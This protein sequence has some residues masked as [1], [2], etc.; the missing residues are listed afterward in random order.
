MPVA[1]FILFIAL[2]CGCKAAPR[3]AESEAPR[4]T[5]TATVITP[6]Q[7]NRGTPVRGP[8]V[9]PVEALS[10]RVIAVR[11]QLRF[12]IV[13][14]PNQKLPRLDQLLSVYRLDQKVAEI[15]VSGPY[16]GSTVAADITA[17]EVREGDLVRDL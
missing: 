2:L 10:G 15:K 12:V 9:R 1:A 3:K 11:E 16:L 5:V 4:K 7:A 17:G 14:F 6:P 8:S 13:N